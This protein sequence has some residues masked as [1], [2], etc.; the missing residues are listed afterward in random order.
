MMIPKYETCKIAIV[1]P[2]GGVS[3]MSFMIVGRGN[4]LP[5]GAVWLDEKVGSW[6]RQPTESVV[7]AEVRRAVPD[8]VAWYR[9]SDDDIPADRT[10]RDALHHN[11]KALVH[12]IEKARGI[13]RDHLRHERASALPLLDNEWM[14]ATGQG[15]RKAAAEVEAKRQKWRDAPADPR[16]E[17]AQTVEELKSIGIPL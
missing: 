1:R 5:D 7:A 2:D 15:D 4:T 16:I 8:Y 11:G 13:K 6:A 3:I 17:T 14:K 9:V 10:F 12:D